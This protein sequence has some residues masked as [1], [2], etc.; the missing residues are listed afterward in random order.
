MVTK[1]V[2]IRIK[3][4]YRFEIEVEAAHSLI[5]GIVKSILKWHWSLHAAANVTDPNRGSQVMRMR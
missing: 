1:N 3:I 4:T 5:I 2:N